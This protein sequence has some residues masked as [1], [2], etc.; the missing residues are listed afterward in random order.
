MRSRTSEDTRSGSNLPFFP[1]ILSA[2]LCEQRCNFRP[3]RSGA[4]SAG[5]GRG[6]TA[7]R[8]GEKTGGQPRHRRAR[9]NTEVDEENELRL[10]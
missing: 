6:Q 8:H 2:V 1:R 4:D 10:K 9:S 5:G 7:H 3:E